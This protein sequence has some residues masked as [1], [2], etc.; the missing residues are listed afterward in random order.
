[1]G[2]WGLSQGINYS[3]HGKRKFFTYKKVDIPA[4]N[5]ISHRELTPQ[6]GKNTILFQ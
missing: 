1:M 5:S 2:D 3:A 6:W 4:E